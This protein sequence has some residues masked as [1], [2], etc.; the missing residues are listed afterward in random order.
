MRTERWSGNVHYFEYSTEFPEPYAG[1][2]DAVKA[3]EAYI[4]AKDQHFA[5]GVV[6]VVTGSNLLHGVTLAKAIA[7]A[8]KKLDA[9]VSPEYAGNYQDEAKALKEN[10][11]FLHTWEGALVKRVV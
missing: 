8:R 6:M 5:L 4:W 9:L 7:A 10:K 3:A 2:M 1:G 11:T